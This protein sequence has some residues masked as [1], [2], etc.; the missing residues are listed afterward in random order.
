V[1]LCFPP[2]GRGPRTDHVQR[3]PFERAAQALPADESDKTALR[4]VSAGGPL[5]CHEVRLLDDAGAELGERRV[6]RLAFRG[7]SATQ[8]YFKK[9]EATAAMAFPDGFLDSGDLAYRAGGE[10]YVCGRRKDII[11]KG[12]RNYV[13]Q[14]IEEAAS[15]AAGV[16]KGCVAAF[17]TTHEAAG[18]ESLIVVAE[19]RATDEAERAR[20]GAAVTEQVALSVGVP[21]DRVELVAPG[22][23]PKTSSGKLRRA[24]AKEQY[25]AGTLGSAPRLPLGQR[26]SLVADAARHGVQPALRRTGRMLYAAYLGLILALPTGAIWLLG[27]IAPAGRPMRALERGFLRLAMLLSGC[28]TTVSGTEN[29]AGPGPFVLACNHA[30]YVDIAALRA[31]VPRQFLFVAKREVLAWPLIGLF[32]RKSGH[33]TVERFDTKDSAAGA[34]KMAQA[35]REGHSVLVFPEGTFTG[36]AGLRPFR[37]GAFK[38]AVETGTPVVP[39]ALRGTRRV[40]RDGEW[41]PRPQPIELRILPPL[42]ATGSEWREVIELRDRV[43]AAVAEHCGEPRLDLVAGGPPRPA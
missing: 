41:L 17:G 24:A 15:Q 28:R 9:P 4:F 34:D 25:L 38:T 33:L 10:I 14:E 11:I 5:P 35:I 13:P 19:T 6:G 2:A 31:L 30:S 37:L 21:P 29:L 40:L 36:A 26:L 16:R 12:G 43:A 32:V 23:L 39:L 22:A 18:T 1:A 8:G 20:I 27:L 3:E 42:R 7:P